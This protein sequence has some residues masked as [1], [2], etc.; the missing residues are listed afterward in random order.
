[1]WFDQF[2]RRYSIRLAGRNGILYS[3]GRRKLAIQG[4]L[5]VGDP[6]FELVLYVSGT[7]RW[8]EN[9]RA[10]AEVSKQEWSVIKEKVNKWING[11]VVW[12]YEHFPTS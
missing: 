9:G 1:M 7:E 2:F 10:G 4:E 8:Q 3:E 11:R 5:L 6:W 12:E